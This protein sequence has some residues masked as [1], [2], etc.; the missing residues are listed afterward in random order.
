MQENGV[1]GTSFH[2][3]ASLVCKHSTA[4]TG[5]RHHVSAGKSNKWWR[6]NVTERRGRGEGDMARD[7]T[8]CPRFPVGG[9]EGS[10]GFE[11]A[12]RGNKRTSGQRRRFPH[13]WVCLKKS[14]SFVLYRGIVRIYVSF[15][16][17]VER[18]WDFEPDCVS[19]FWFRIGYFWKLLKHVKTPT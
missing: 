6:W 4:A 10:E 5:P 1:F 3:D 2:I 17:S 9:V 16:S 18:F 13:H 14:R 11:R 15:E 8:N 12:K 19:I 7:M